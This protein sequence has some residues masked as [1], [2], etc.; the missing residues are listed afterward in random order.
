MKKKI[1]RAGIFGASLLALGAALT[2]QAAAQDQQPT[3]AAQPA[4][5]V[6]ED[7]EVVVV[8]SRI[9]RDEFNSTVPI[10]VITQEESTRAG[11]ASTTEV[12]QSNAATN[13][14]A[15]INNLFGGFVVNGGGGV[16]TLGLRGF[17][18]TS[19]LILLN[20]RRLTPAGSRGAVGAADL[21]TLP[22]ALVER[23]EILKDGASS[24]YGSDAVAGVVN[25][26]T[27]ENIDGFILEGQRNFSETAGGDQSRISLSGSAEF[28]NLSLIGSLEYYE[29]EAIKYADREF[30][31]CPGDG[32]RNPVTGAEIFETSPVTGERLC[33]NL[34]YT[35]SPGVTIN[36]IGTAVRAGWGGPGAA[37]T[38][39][40]NRWRPASFNSDGAGGLLDGF[41]GVN[42][43]GVGFANRDQFEPEMLEGDFVTPVETTNFFIAGQYELPGN[44]ELYGEVLLSHRESNSI[45]YRQLSLDYPNNPLLPAELRLG[46]PQAPTGL[47]SV[48]PTN[49]PMPAQ[50]AVQV[51]AFIGWGLYDSVQEVDYVR[52]VGGLRGDLPVLDD[53]RYDFNVYYGRN[54]GY[55]S[56]ENLLVDRVYNSLN[57]APAVGGEPANLVR[58]VNGV[59]YV[60]QITLTNPGYGCIPA[61]ALTA[62]MIGGEIPSNWANWVEQIVSSLNIYTETSLSFV[63]DGPVMELPAGAVQ[64]V[65][66]LEHRFAEID[67]TPDFNSVNS[68]VFAFA[69]SL[70]TRG[71]D[72]VTEVFGEVEVPILQDAP[73]A[74]S[75]TLN[76]SAR[77][78]DYESYGADQTY[79]ITG[80]WEPIDDLL[81]RYSTGTSYRA[82][83]LFEQ[84]L[85][86][87]T[88]FASSQADPCNNYGALPPT[89]Q[90]Y[91]NC[92][93]QIGN[94]AFQQLNGVTIFTGGGAATNLFAE[95]STNETIGVSW[96]PLR[97]SGGWGDLSI[98]ADHFSIEL[99]DTVT[100][101][102]NSNILARCYTSPNPA[103]E[104]L[105]SLVARDALNRLTV[106]D[107]YTN[108][109]SQRS[110]GW[111]Y[112]VRYMHDLFD[113]EL[114]LTAN[115][116]QFNV[117]ETQFTPEF[118]PS[119]NNGRMFTPEMSGDFAANYTRGPWTVHYGFT[120]VQGMDDYGDNGK[121]PFTSI[122]DLNTPDYFLH[123]TSVQYEAETWQLT[124]GVRNLL[125]EQPPTIWS[126]DTVVAGAAHGAVPLFSGY[127][128]VGRQFFANV[129]TRF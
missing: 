92:H 30:L 40:F 47:P 93:A 24:V 95:T 57:I 9:R 13:G 63:I 32:T 97:D 61:P 84:F 125:D 121:N 117:Q 115:L 2:P 87:N 88:G 56:F 65:F 21:N 27:R 91:I 18:P 33:W 16:N 123:N 73:L 43:G 14:S 36:T 64:A 55:S 37:F 83:A 1:E 45:G 4:D 50:Y 70:P 62:D 74:R 41:E 46:G 108:L 90:V 60:C 113:G 54:E 75:L 110:E 81:F 127:D 10:Q 38:G 34:A 122:E 119:D 42:G 71:E 58:N 120:W 6:E 52:Y 80:S 102:G 94:T 96:R 106:F 82:P 104:P 11:F 72:S 85:G 29:R 15:Q 5:E 8:G 26:I 99:S 128:P 12:L 51:R 129:S 79:K 69:S 114:T 98:A 17:G 116:T 67:D 77:H 103:T 109:S 111:D 68:N 107:L 44:H 124:L 89:S 112:G 126:G 3:Q 66:G 76:V 31:R 100:R 7:E 20:G 86:F 53:W 19:T 22:S 59:D 48:M 105:C 101:W 35:S 25:I 23:I 78:T 39:N 49:V 28:G 118:A